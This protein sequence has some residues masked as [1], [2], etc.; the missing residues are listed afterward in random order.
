MSI[1]VMLVY[2]LLGLIVVITALGMLTSRNAVYSALFLVLN[3]ATVAVLYMTLGAPF[4]ALAQ[5]S[6]YAGA[7]MVLFLFVIMLLGAEHITQRS[8]GRGH[9]VLSVLVA[10]ALLAEAVIYILFRGAGVEMAAL[11]SLPPDFASPAA[12]GQLL[13][14][15][16]LLP[17]EIT[18][19]ILLS[20]VIGAIYLTRRE[21]QAAARTAAAEQPA[22]KPVE[23][24]A[25]KTP[26]Y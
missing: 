22:E 6:V 15:Q 14:S 17:F 4:I 19:V 7:I 26:I 18:A 24:P 20:A 2:G 3:F 11:P 13:F 9:R 5:V 16:F 10:V 1:G 12:I 21:R 8:T 23:E 25:E